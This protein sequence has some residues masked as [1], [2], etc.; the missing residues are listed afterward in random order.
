MV[1]VVQ[2]VVGVVGMLDASRVT[3]HNVVVHAGSHA[4]TR[5]PLYLQR[6][7]SQVHHRLYFS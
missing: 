6:K 3:A 7:Q 1:R 4:G 2:V 5:V